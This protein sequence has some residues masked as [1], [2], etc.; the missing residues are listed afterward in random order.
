VRRQVVDDH[1]RM[2]HPLTNRLLLISPDGVSEFCE[3]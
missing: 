2:D 3:N 1:A